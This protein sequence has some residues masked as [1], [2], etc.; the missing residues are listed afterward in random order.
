MDNIK[1]TLGNYTNSSQEIHY[2]DRSITHMTIY[3]MCQADEELL[4]EFS[5]LSSLRLVAPTEEFLHNFPHSK[6]ITKLAISSPKGIKNLDF[7][8]YYP[9]LEEFAFIYKDGFLKNI[10]GLRYLKNLTY[11]HLSL[12]KETTFQSLDNILDTLYNLDNLTFLR[13]PGITFNNNSLLPLGKCKNIQTINIAFYN[14]PKNSW[15]ELF[16][17][18]PYITRCFRQIDTWFDRIIE[19]SQLPVAKYIEHLDFI[20]PSGIKDLQI[21]QHFP[22]ISKFSF[23][24]YSKKVSLRGLNHLDKLQHLTLSSFTKITEFKEIIENL[25]N[26]KNIKTLHL[27]H[28]P[29]LTNLDGIKQLTN[30][31]E[32]IFDGIHIGSVPNVVKIDSLKPLANLKKLNK[33]QLFSL[34]IL[35]D[36]LLVLKS[37][38][39]LKYLQI[40]GKMFPQEQFARLSAYFPNI[41]G[42]SLVPYN[43]WS[44]RD[45]TGEK[46]E[47][48]NVVG[49]RKRILTKGKD[50]HLLEKEVQKFNAFRDDEL[51]KI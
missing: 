51:T 30:L 23:D 44:Y 6:N 10:Q 24:N 16:D 38:T 7:L 43:N 32:F 2:L 21:L 47:Q 40:E 25:Y 3:P 8:Q 9:N 46:I 34:K 50:E 15:E 39:N 11:L 35:D 48:Y 5:S 49:R 14:F 41:E 29:K 36:D 45:S 22:N 12:H 4:Q 26:S 42:D 20:D 13:L 27:E 1:S 28:F 33:L 37:L 31:E 19:L 17:T 18:Y